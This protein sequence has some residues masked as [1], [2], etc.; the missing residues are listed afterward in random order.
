[1]TVD[2]AM[3]SEAQRARLTR[4]DTLKSEVSAYGFKGS[5]ATHRGSR[6][7][8]WCCGQWAETRALIY[9]V[10]VGDCCIWHVIP[11]PDKMSEDRLREHIRKLANLY[12]TRKRSTGVTA[13]G[14]ACGISRGHLSEF[15]SGRRGPS[16]DLLAALGLE[17][18]IVRALLLKDNSDA[19]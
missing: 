8:C 12:V 9:N 2:I 16:A 18:R 7:E 11:P 19:G 4:I 15:M 10:Q 3:L 5:L 14:R 1:M 17:W 6:A 13:W